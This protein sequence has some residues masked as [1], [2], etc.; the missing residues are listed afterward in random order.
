MKGHLPRGSSSVLGA[1]RRARPAGR[2]G[3]SSM[4][5]REQAHDGCL[6]EHAFAAWGVTNDSAPDSEDFSWGSLQAKST[7]RWL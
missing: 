5:S 2:R 1:P 3:F 6:R 7:S 4:P